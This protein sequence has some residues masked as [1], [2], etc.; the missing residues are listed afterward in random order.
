MTPFRIPNLWRE[1]NPRAKLVSIVSMQ[2]H[3][4]D[5]GSLLIGYTEGAVIYSFKQNKAIKFFHYEVPKGAPGGDS[6]PRTAGQPRVPRMTHALWHPTGTFIMTAHEDTSL[7]FWDP[8]DGR[9][10]EARTVEDVAVNMPGGRVATGPGSLAASIKEPYSRI[11]W[12]SKT[13]P[14][15]TGILFVGGQLAT[16][17]TPGITFMDFGQTP[18]YQTSSWDF[19]TGHF[20]NP[21]RTHILPSPPNVKVTDFL[22]IPRSSPHFAGSHDPIA[23]MTVLSSG[24]IRTMSFPSGYPISPS[25]QLHVSMSLVHPYLTKFALSDVDRKRWLGMKESRQHGPNFL[26]G[27]AE[28]SKLMKRYESRNIIQTAHADG[29]I[30][31]WDVG[32]GDEIENGGVMQADLARAVGRWDNI[33]VTQ[34]CMSGT[35]GELAVGLRSGEVVVFRL[36]RN[37]NFG[38]PTLTLVENEGPG[39]LTNTTRR[40]D[41]DLKEGLMPLTLA[42]E[43]QGP[44][45]AMKLS[46]V[47]FLAAGYESG[48]LTVI[49]LR[50]PAIIHT[51]MLADLAVKR[52]GSISG[53][54]KGRR[55]SRSTTNEHPSV[56]EFGVMTIEG[57]G[58]SKQ[59]DIVTQTNVSRLLL[60]R[61]VRRHQSWSG[62]HFQNTSITVWQILRSVFRCRKPGQ[63]SG[64]LDLS[65]RRRHWRP[66]LCDRYSNGR[67]PDRPKDRWCPCRDNYY[68]CSY[69]QTRISKRCLKDFRQRFLRRSISNTLRATWLRPR[70][71]FRRRHSSGILPT[72]SQRLGNNPSQSHI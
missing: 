25:N 37:S 59:V 15:D 36:N 26:L 34:M 52:H 50:G 62:S 56:I 45:T 12:C 16:S 47:G 57:D 19:L 27:G 17:P 22:I 7:V 60:D 3:P 67:P 9:I 24:E 32:C 28:A 44:V 18:N 49:D 71:S 64:S 40:A 65:H 46:N 72:S 43:Q 23:V 70:R 41:P 42:N 51:A 69:F 53:T 48:G 13:N 66:C 6:D 1:K 21:K 29:T 33:D 4:K 31:I 20:R 5:I 61:D 68:F 58:E 14:D 54:I 39:Q 8:R 35:T 38:G 30:R 55:Q 11:A 10:L 2:Y 63:R